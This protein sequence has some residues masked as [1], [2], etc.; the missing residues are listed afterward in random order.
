MSSSRLSTHLTA[1]ALV[2]GITGKR[3]RVSNRLLPVRSS[4]IRWWHEQHPLATNAQ[5]QRVMHSLLQ[6][7]IAIHLSYKKVLAGNDN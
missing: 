5:V 2:E 6:Q 1:S 3:F 7:D 4:F